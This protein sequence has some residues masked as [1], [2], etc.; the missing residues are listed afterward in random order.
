MTLIRSDRPKIVVIAG[1]TGVGKTSLS[2][3][4][5]HRFGAE[6]VNADSMQVYRHMDIGTAKPTRDEQAEIRHHLIDIVNPDQNFDAAAYL[7]LARPLIANLH[8]WGRPVIVVGGTGLYLRSLLRGLFTGPG[9][10]PELRTRLKHEAALDGPAALHARLAHIDPVTAARLHPNDLVRV[11]R[12]LEVYEITGRPMSELQSEH[13]L[14]EQP[15]HVLFFCLNLPRDELYRRIDIRTV[16]MFAGG[17]VG[18]VEKLLDL[19]YSPGLKPMRA[20]GY[21]EIVRHLAGRAGLA[22]T[23]TE[24]AKQTRHFA[25]RQLTWFR[26]QP[27][28]HWLTPEECEG[29]IERTAAFWTGA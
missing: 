18:E 1:P 25:K 23:M 16:E 29:T 4:L 28:V 21:K 7:S 27:D 5:A 10:D 12:A 22:E 8:A 20:I 2:V 15:Y 11:I 19:G 6:I 24:I 3:S 13:A 14:A 26:A 9:Q 17:W